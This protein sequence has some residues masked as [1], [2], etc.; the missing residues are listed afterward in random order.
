MKNATQKYVIS[1]TQNSSMPANDR[2]APLLKY[3]NELT[4]SRLREI[5]ARREARWTPTARALKLSK[6][7]AI[8]PWEK[9]TGPKT[10]DGKSKSCQNAFKHGE[11]SLILTRFLYQLRIQ[12]IFCR[13][14]QAMTKSRMAMMRRQKHRAIA[15]TLRGLF[16]KRKGINLIRRYRALKIINDDKIEV[17]GFTN[18]MLDSMEKVMIHV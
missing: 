11:R 16:L 17:F 6:I 15:H 1:P 14:L 13:C 7:R 3:A 5:K 12:A 10:A 18:P 8:K 2:L 4:D 9:S